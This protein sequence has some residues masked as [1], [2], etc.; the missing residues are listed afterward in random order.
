MIVKT[1]QTCF[2]TL[3]LAVLATNL[4]FI[5]C[6]RK[7]PKPNFETAGGYVIGKEKC[8]ADTT[9][10]YWLIDLSI[11]PSPSNYGDTLTLN[12]IACNNAVKTN[13][14]FPQFKF[15]GARVGFDFYISPSPLQTVNCTLS[16]PTTFLLK[17]IE[18]L[19]QA[20]IR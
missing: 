14:L 16:N 2:I 4:C 7:N 1:N 15:I 8:K 5:Y 18:I 17:K 10:D 6:N 9:Q 11:Y 13:Q 3:L 20:E 19:R 12:G